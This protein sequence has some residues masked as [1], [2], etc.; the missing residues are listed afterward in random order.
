MSAPDASSYVGSP[1]SVFRVMAGMPSVHPRPNGPL[2]FPE[3]YDSVSWGPKPARPGDVQTGTVSEPVP[4]TGLVETFSPIPRTAPPPLG[5]DTTG[6]A[7]A[8]A[9]GRAAVTAPK[10]PDATS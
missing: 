10:D 8:C 1:L 2:P 5:S 7:M 4:V 9:S 3:S 6:G